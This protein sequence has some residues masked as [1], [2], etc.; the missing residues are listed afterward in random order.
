MPAIKLNYKEERGGYRLNKLV[1]YVLSAS[2]TSQGKRE[3]SVWLVERYFWL[4]QKLDGV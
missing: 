4:Y 1:C 3:H 2:F